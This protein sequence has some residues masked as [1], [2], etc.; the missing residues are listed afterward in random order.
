[1]MLGDAILVKPVTRSVMIC[2]EGKEDS[3]PSDRVSVRLPEGHRWCDPAEKTWY[4]GGETVTV[5]APIDRIPLFVRSGA[6]LTLGAEADNTEEQAKLPLDVVIFPGEDGG[7]TL[8]QDAGD[9]YGYEQGE[10]SRVRLTW[11][12]RP[13][14]LTI[15]AREGSWPGMREEMILRIRRFGE[16]PEEIRYRGEPIVWQSGE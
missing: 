16:T 15:S 7:E 14:R 11:E 8:Y 3:E 10:C 9:G 4:G 2:P 12:D 13:G 1:M 5:H 6:V